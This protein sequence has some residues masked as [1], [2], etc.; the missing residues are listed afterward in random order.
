MEPA[1][2]ATEA[3]L[4]PPAPSR[5]APARP[6]G[7]AP[8]HRSGVRARA[9][10][11]M[12]IGACAGGAL[13]DVAA[14]SGPATIAVTIWLVAIAVVILLSGRVSGLTSKALVAAGAVL[15]L[16]FTLR[17]SPWVLVPA[18]F[19]IGLVFLLGVSLGADG[20]GL[21]MPFPALIT[22]LVYVLGH[23]LIAPGMFRPSAD[24]KTETMQRV[25]AA[26]RG[27]LFGVPIMLVVGVLL[28]TADPIFRSWF[29]VGPLLQHALLIVAGAWIVTG[30]VRAASAQE[31][32]GELQAPPALGTIEAA[33]VLGGLCA[34]YAVFAVAQLTA[35]SGA[36]HRI[37]VTHGLTYAQ[38][39]RSGFFQLLACAAITLIVALVVRAC[40]DAAS[41]VLMSLAGLTVVLTTG[42]VV[43]AV[44]RL[45]LYEAV[46]GLTMLRLACFMVAGWIGLVFVLLGLTIPP[47]GLRVRHFPAAFVVSGLVLVA[48]WGASNPASIVAHT[49]LSR[50]SHAS[51]DV[52]QAASLGPDAVPTLL[53]ELGSL[54]APDIAWL[55]S[56]VCGSHDRVQAAGAGSSF[57]LSH[58]AAANACRTGR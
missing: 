13:F 33:L 56:S 30:L 51:F 7:P 11:R 45:D 4:V 23:V 46:F 57:N 52:E 43:V 3:A 25:T 21:S 6:S 15:S 2:P 9:D 14:R 10:K 37:L 35:L 28:A 40:T 53:S 17:A 31:P 32:A 18:G 41:K 26:V 36:G 27:L 8:G 29:D 20:T 54:S 58:A 16:L 49:D 1:Q 55:R 24:C 44:R 22:R 5:P 12:I 48:V 50:A 34:L 42:I 39:A 38:Y 19:A 47:R